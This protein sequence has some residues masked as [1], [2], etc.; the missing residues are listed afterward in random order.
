MHL[1]SHGNRR[2]PAGRSGSGQCRLAFGRLHSPCF[3]PYLVCDLT[4][5]WPI[6]DPAADATCPRTAEPVASPS[7]PQCRSDVIAPPDYI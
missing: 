2:K 6:P 4:D 3:L 7:N 5:A 1:G